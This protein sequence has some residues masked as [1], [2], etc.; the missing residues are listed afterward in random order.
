M[1]SYIRNFQK[2][3]KFAKMKNQLLHFCNKKLLH[4]S[5]NLSYFYNNLS[6]LY[7][8]LLQKCYTFITKMQKWV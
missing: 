7:N 6:L 3:E 8:K 5:N 1:V 2:I 4:F